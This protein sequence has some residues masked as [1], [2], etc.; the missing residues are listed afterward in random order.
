[1]N[2]NPLSPKKYYKSFITDPEKKKKRL[3]LSMLYVA[4]L[5]KQY[6]LFTFNSRKFS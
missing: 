1:M 4:L 5:F 3:I 2:L 6:S